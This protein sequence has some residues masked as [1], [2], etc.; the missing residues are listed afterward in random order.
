[1]V[2]GSKGEGV[3]EREVQLNLWRKRRRRRGR[4]K[5]S[6]EHVPVFCHYAEGTGS[7]TRAQVLECH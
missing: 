5:Y 7:V 6:F 1:M 4:R 2:I 3:T